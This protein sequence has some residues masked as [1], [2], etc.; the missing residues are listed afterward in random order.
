MEYYFLSMMIIFLKLSAKCI[1]LSILPDR[2][3]TFKVTP[4]SHPSLS[5]THRQENAKEFPVV[6]KEFKRERRE[7]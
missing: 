7:I 4:T 3:T 5:H 6:L 1:S 2:I